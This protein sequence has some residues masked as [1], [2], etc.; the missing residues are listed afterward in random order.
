MRFSIF[1]VHVVKDNIQKS[2]VL[3]ASPYGSVKR[4]RWS[5]VECRTALKLFG[6]NI[7]TGK[8]PSFEEI[9]KIKQEHGELN[10]RSSPQ[11]KTWIHNQIKKREL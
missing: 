2:Y 4:R 1:T 3:P 11:I 10:A 7:R 5:E 9:K 6:T 8:L